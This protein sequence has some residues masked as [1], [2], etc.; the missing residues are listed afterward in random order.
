MYTLN[1]QVNGFLSTRSFVNLALRS[2]AVR[3]PTLLLIKFPCIV[4]SCCHY[5]VLVNFF[6][7]YPHCFLFYFCLFI[8]LLCI[9]VFESEASLKTRPLFR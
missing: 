9:P 3:L 7:G 1:M 2:A 4:F 8:N 6:S 5:S